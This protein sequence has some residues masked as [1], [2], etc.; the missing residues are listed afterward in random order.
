MIKICEY[1]KNS[2]TNKRRHLRQCT[3][4]P[5]LSN[6]ERARRISNGMKKAH[7]ENRHQGLAYTRKNQ[8]GMSYPEKWFSEVIKNNF[9]DKNFEYNLPVGHYKLDF[10]WKEKMRYIEIDGKQHNETVEYDEKRDAFIKSF[11]WE[12]L[13]LKWEFIINNKELAIN[14]AKNFIDSGEKKDIFWKSKDELSKEKRALCESK[15]LITSNGRLNV[16]GI[17][18]EEYERRKNL[19]L[20]CGVDIKKFGWVRKVEDITG[21]TKRQIEKVVN[22]FNLDVYKR[23]C[24]QSCLRNRHL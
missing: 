19:I 14:I 18:I 6:E 16:N 22:H 1:C 7:A 17:S 23:K 8:F 4:R 11:G 21:L 2:Y 10:A 24:S 3:C 9:T 5:R 13:R 20:E 12:C 15:G